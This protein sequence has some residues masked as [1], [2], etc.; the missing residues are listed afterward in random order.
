MLLHDE[1]DILELVMGMVLKRRSR[2][3]LQ[4][5]NRIFD[6]QEQRNKA[7]EYRTSLIA[8]SGVRTS[9]LDGMPKNSAISDPTGKYAPLIA[10]CDDEI[11]RLDKQIEERK[12]AAA[13][14]INEICDLRIRLMF[15]LRFFQAHAWCEVAAAMGTSEEACKNLVYRYLKKTSKR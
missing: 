9:S 12:A 8:A 11:S 3:T 15:R 14:F 4:E 2:M 1:M 6:L 7:V 10:E 5:L 13:A